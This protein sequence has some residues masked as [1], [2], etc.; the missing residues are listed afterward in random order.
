LCGIGVTSLMLVMMSP[1]ICSERM[2][3]SRPP[4]GPLTNTSTCRSPYSLAFLAADSA[5]IW[6]A[7][8]VPFLEPLNPAVPELPQE[9][10]FPAGSVSV[11][12]TL[13]KV[14]WIY[15]LPCGT[16]FLS[17]F[18]AIRFSF[19]SHETPAPTRYFLAV[20]RRLPLPATVWRGPRR[21]LALVRV[22]CP[23]TGNLRRCLMPR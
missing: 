10:T 8:G 19:S 7:Y 5:A 18:L 21:V 4:P 6:A 13:L 17:F 2:A 23:R 9:S 22:R 14:E 3:A 11:T 1:A 16:D 20:P 15:A 12:I